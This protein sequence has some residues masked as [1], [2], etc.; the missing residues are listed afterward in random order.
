MRKDTGR[1]IGTALG[2]V[3]AVAAYTLTGPFGLITLAS[4]IE[5]VDA[6]AC[7]GEAVARAVCE[8]EPS[9]DIKIAIY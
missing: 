6:G 3:A 2:G 5:I 9:Y 8:A 1:I 7:L 4:A